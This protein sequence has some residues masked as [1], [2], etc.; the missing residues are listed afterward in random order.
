[1]ALQILVATTNQ[2]KVKELRTLLELDRQ[3]ETEVVLLSLSEV[4]GVPE[5]E[6]DAETFAGN[7]R[8]KA[9]AYAAVTGLWTISDDSGLV[10][11]AL[12]GRPGVN[13]ARFSGVQDTDRSVVDK[14]N[15][16]KVL[17]LMR[18]VPLTDRTARFKC[19]LCMAAPDRVQI[20]TE[21]TV[22]GL[23][24]TEPVGAGGFGYDPIFYLPSLSKTMAQLDMKEKNAISHRGN[25][26]RRLKPLLEALIHSA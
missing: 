3:G 20:E 19:C 15:I 25:A 13:S 11:D 26:I 22:E 6:E 10:I 18:N 23:I 8:K 16:Q 17:D 14:K 12:G 1:M 2:G 7:A 24:G 9:T 21:G 5:V 4:A